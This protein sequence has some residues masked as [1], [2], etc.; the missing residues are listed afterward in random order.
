M[1]PD[2]EKHLRTVRELASVEPLTE[3]PRLFGALEEIRATA[4]IRL[5]QPAPTPIQDTLLDVHEAAE[6]L[7]MGRDYLYRN[8][9]KF[10]FTRRMGRRLLFSSEG[11]QQY[12]TQQT[13]K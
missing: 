6:L 10:S 7:G 12:I 5:L 8:H 4:Q 1:S 13:H 11:I 9:N 3:L 2:L